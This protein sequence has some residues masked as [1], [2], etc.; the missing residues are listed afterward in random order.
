MQT[1]LIH[2][3]ITGLNSINDLLFHEIQNLIFVNNLLLLVP[4]KKLSY[5]YLLHPLKEQI[6]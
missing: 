2:F 1:H 4:Q 3:K 6:K 5:Q